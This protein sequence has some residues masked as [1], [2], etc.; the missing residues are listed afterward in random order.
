MAEGKFC[1]KLSA[2]GGKMRFCGTAIVGTKG[3]IVI[4]KDV[5]DK[6]GL[7]PGTGVTIVVKDERAVA[8]IRNDDLLNLIECARAEGV[9][10][11]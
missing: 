11:E 7:Q 4:P 5:R 1:D 3:Q 8:L 2:S 10:L 6:L 9:T